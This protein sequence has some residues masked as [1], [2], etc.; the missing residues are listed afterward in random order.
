MVFSKVVLYG[1]SWKPEGL[2]MHTG[3][4][5]QGSCSLLGGLYLSIPPPIYPSTHSPYIYESIQPVHVIEAYSVLSSLL[6]LKNT[7]MNMVEKVSDSMGTVFEWRH[8]RGQPDHS[9]DKKMERDGSSLRQQAPFTCPGAYRHI[10]NIYE[11]AQDVHVPTHAHPWRPTYIY[12]VIC[13][14]THRYLNA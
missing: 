9:Y 3:R 6:G 4:E 7:A 11:C 5:D 8:P 13:A 1:W 2:G 12:K 14:H 10:Y